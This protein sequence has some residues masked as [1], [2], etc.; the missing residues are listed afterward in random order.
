MYQ[1]PICSRQRPK[2]KE[3]RSKPADIEFS[4]KIR[5]DVNSYSHLQDWE[6]T[7][8]LSRNRSTEGASV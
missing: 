8:N 6:N 3:Q 1:R 2:H 7:A 4:T 5:I